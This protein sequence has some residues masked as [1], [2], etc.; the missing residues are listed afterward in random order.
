VHRDRAG[1]DA[2]HGVAVVVV[3]AG[4]VDGEEGGERRGGACGGW[5]DAGAVTR[6][7]VRGGVAPGP[8]SIRFIHVFFVVSRKKAPAASNFGGDVQRDSPK[9]VRF[10]QTKNAHDS[11]FCRVFFSSTRAFSRASFRKGNFSTEEESPGGAPRG[12]RLTTVR[13]RAA[14]AEP[15]A[16]RADALRTRRAPI[17]V[18]DRARPGSTRASVH[19]PS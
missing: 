2:G 12:T 9:A 1:L 3:N 10:R 19:R 11:T 6:V 13:T 4:R 14:D 8:R 18:E 7:R 5:W 15:R 16:A 17:R